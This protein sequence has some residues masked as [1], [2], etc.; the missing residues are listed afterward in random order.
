MYVSYSSQRIFFLT[1]I[2]FR[3]AFI[4]KAP[5]HPLV[6]RNEPGLQKSGYDF[7][8][9]P[10]S[11]KLNLLNHQLFGHYIVLCKYLYKIDS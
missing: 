4:K 10:D 2:P 11:A 6:W 8:S 1:V 7:K 9:C 3:P 5:I